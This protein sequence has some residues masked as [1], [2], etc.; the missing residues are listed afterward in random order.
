MVP[1]QGGRSTHWHAIVANVSPVKLRFT[2]EHRYTWCCYLWGY[3]VVEPA[4]PHQSAEWSACGKGNQRPVR[5]V[6]VVRQS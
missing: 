5:S 2:V 3:V 6:L 4:L 1:G